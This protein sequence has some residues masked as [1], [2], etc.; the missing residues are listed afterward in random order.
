ML[1]DK[2][3]DRDQFYNATK[4]YVNDFRTSEIKGHPI[5]FLQ[6]FF[7]GLKAR[8]NVFICRN[9]TSKSIVPMFLAMINAIF[10]INDM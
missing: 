9:K 7:D 6:L 5:L 8:L 2:A 3:H 1:C 4:R 10:I